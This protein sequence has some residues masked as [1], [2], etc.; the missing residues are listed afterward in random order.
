M[1]R[2]SCLASRSSSCARLQHLRKAIAVRSPASSRIKA[3]PS[4][5]APPSPPR[6]RRR[7]CRASPVTDA[8]GYYVL[9]ALPP[10]IYDVSVEL[11]GFKKWTQTGVTLDAASSASVQA[12]LETGT[13]SE[14]DHGHGRGDAAPDRRR[15]AQDGRSQGHRA[16]GVLGP[17]SD[18]RRRLEGRRDGRRVQQPR[19]RR[20]RQRRLQHQR[21]P[22]RREHDFDRRRHRRPHAIERQHRRRFRT[23]MPCR[24]CRC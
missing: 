11:D 24:R 18:R 2:W 16:D 20:S 7:S 4:F 23:S 5:P 22:H 17:Q 19:L 3:A 21:Q 13:I 6:T 8:R 14:V 15:G 1:V 10:G 12:V 9:P